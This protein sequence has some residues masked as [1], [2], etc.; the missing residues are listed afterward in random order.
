MVTLHIENTVHD[1]D[2]WKG[3]FDKFD[4]FRAD[5][6]VRSYRL[7]RRVDDGNQITVDLEFGTAEQA[8]AF[9]GALEQ[10]WRTPQSREQL[11]DHGTPVLYE[12]ADEK[13]FSATAASTA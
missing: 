10:I 12:V 4:R 5:H 13:V 7:S 2:A 9:R 8:I 6:G 11:I 1:Y 3:V